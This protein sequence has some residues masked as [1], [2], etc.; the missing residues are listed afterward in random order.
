MN[1][2]VNNKLIDLNNF[3]FTQL[4]RLNDDDVSEETLVKEI[5]RSKAMTAVG[6]TIIKNA[7]L[8]LEG[9]KFLAEYT[10]DGKDIYL[11]EMM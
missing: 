4:E 6:N 2:N 1:N 11:P 9:R 3:L 5:K 8:A 7:E 10:R